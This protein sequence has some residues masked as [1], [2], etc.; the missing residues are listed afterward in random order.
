M[1]HQLPRTP[2]QRASGT[3]A[4][5]LLAQ[6]CKTLY[7]VST[8]A[9]INLWPGTRDPSGD[10]HADG[11]AKQLFNSGS[12]DDEEVVDTGSAGEKAARSLMETLSSVH[13]KILRLPPVVHSAAAT[14]VADLLDTAE[15][16][17]TER[18]INNMQTAIGK[19][20]DPKRWTYGAGDG[21]HYKDVA[22]MWDGWDTHVLKK[23]QKVRSTA[24]KCAELMKD[25]SCT[26][27]DPRLFVCYVRA[28]DSA[29]PTAAPP[30]APAE[31]APKETSSPALDVAHARFPG[32]EGQ[33][34]KVTIQVAG[35]TPDCLVAT[36]GA[37]ERRHVLTAAA[38]D[39]RTAPAVSAMNAAL[40]RVASHIERDVDRPTHKL[41][42]FVAANVPPSPAASRSCSGAKLTVFNEA[43][44]VD[45]EFTNELFYLIPE[46]NYA[47][48][49]NLEASSKM[50]PVAF[51]TIRQAAS[52]SPRARSLLQLANS[53]QNAARAAD[54]ALRSAAFAASVVSKAIRSGEF[55]H[56][57]TSE[58]K[59]QKDS[60]LQ[61]ALS[62]MLR[63]AQQNT[64]VFAQAQYRT[65]ADLAGAPGMLL[66]TDAS[67]QGAR[68]GML[69]DGDM[70]K[71]Q[72]L[73]KDVKAQQSLLASVQKAQKQN[74]WSPAGPSDR[75]AAQ[76]DHAGGA[77]AAGANNDKKRKR[78]KHSKG[79]KGNKGDKGGKGGKG[80]NHN[81]RK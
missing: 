6:Q 81:Q 78:T 61:L 27:W 4:Y 40:K 33:G 76:D 53:T 60:E 29:S 16:P 35:F 19:L 68:Q 13:H 64:M 8:P 46:L 79:G 66:E 67:T 36:G 48:G 77:S 5:Q 20:A 54:M 10:A 28:P 21:T 17:L 47:P 25:D 56:T 11:L 59:D 3:A 18:S 42:P 7:K 55:C 24:D 71:L 72:Q 1:Y 32:T 23:L 69:N 2:P 41:D 44:P 63:T 52:K 14:A 22:A 45:R 80:G 65:L 30:A 50:D 12:D 37:S 15:L 74:S 57:G 9:N 34:K 26:A 39:V 31:S 75:G 58:E 49:S 51:A 62:L 38:S 43:N 70:Q 73:Q